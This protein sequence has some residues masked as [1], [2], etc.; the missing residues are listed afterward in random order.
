MKKEKQNKV[1]N[2]YDVIIDLLNELRAKSKIKSIRDKPL[3]KK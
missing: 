2:M 3:K 1:Y